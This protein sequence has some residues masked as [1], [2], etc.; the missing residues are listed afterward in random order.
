MIYQ[1]LLLLLHR[2]LFLIPP[3]LFQPWKSLIIAPNYLKVTNYS[4][5][6][7]ISLRGFGGAVSHSA[8]ISQCFDF[9]VVT[10]LSNYKIVSGN[11]EDKIK[12]NL[13]L[14]CKICSTC[15]IINK[16]ARAKKHMETIGHALYVCRG[17]LL[18]ET[19]IAYTLATMCIYHISLVL[20]Y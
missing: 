7:S 4:Y 19:I 15:L 17:W 2:S 11:K 8:V 13:T 3:Y 9:V 14:L 1:S 16:I 18:D 6:T 12:R 10:R 5:S 20:H